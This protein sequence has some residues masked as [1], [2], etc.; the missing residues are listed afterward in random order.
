[1]RYGRIRPYCIISYGSPFDL[2]DDDIIR[3]ICRVIIIKQQARSKPAV[4]PGNFDTRFPKRAT[5]PGLG[6]LALEC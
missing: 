3:M 4:L 6:Q 1:M 5:K 2:D